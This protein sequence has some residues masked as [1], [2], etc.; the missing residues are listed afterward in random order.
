M[1]FDP[2]RR[3]LLAA[4]LA[5]GVGCAPSAT[6]TRASAPADTS[7]ALTVAI[8]SRPQPFDPALAVS[9]EQG[10]VARPAYQRLLRR[11]TDPESGAT[12]FTPDLAQAWESNSDH[13]AWTFLLDPAQRFDDGAPVDAA[14]V[15]FSFD[16]LIALGRGPATKAIQSIARI[17]APSPREVRFHLRASHPRFPSIVA[18]RATAI[19][20]PAIMAHAL[21]GDWASGWLS[22]RSAGSGAYRLLPEPEGGVYVLERNPHFGGAP[23]HMERLVFREMPDPT[24]RAFAVMRGEADIAL[25]MPAQAL[26]RV[27]REPGVRI[28]SVRTTA[29]QNLAFNLD[30]PV[31]QDLR[32]RRAVASAV[33]VDA[34][35]QHIRGG[36]ASAFYG[37]LAQGMPGAD[38]EL[39]PVRYDPEG[40]AALALAAL[41]NHTAS[42]RVT[43]IYPGVSPETDTVAQYVQAVLVPVGLQV[44]LERLSVPAYLDRTAR[45]AYDLVLMG[46]VAEDDE[47]ASLLNFWFNPERVGVQ[48]PARYRDAQTFAL[49]QQAETV[50]GDAARA[51]IF[52]QVARRVNAQLPYVYLQQTHLLFLA[53]AE[54]EGLRFD[55]V[56]GL[57]LPWAG[58]RRLA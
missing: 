25:L 22:V 35:R 11:R 16:R 13:R 6:G 12:L 3:S 34:I 51:E 46:F 30:R 44:R 37:P 53:R 47:P 27:E 48:N 43:M 52:R 31:F 57:D 19:V 38:P 17:E 2:R 7:R 50:S 41:P 56:D 33:D 8:V 45:G 49:I 54:I 42:Q 9:A 39:Y 55:P 26:R 21:D 40:A 24:L 29:Y 4:G 36:H 58:M 15:K 14:A 32:L 23:A 18:D 20:N 28:V 5:F 10:L 1:S